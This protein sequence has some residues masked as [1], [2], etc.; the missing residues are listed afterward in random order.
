M[1]NRAL[2][3]L[4]GGLDSATVTAIAVK[5]KRECAA[6]TFSYGQRHTIEIASAKKLVEFFK[7]KNHIVIEIPTAVFQGSALLGQSGRDVPKNR[8]ISKLDEIPETY[9]PARNILFL[10]YALACAESVGIGDIYIGV[11]ALDYSGYPDCRP[12]FIAAYEKMANL[13][14]RSGVEGRPFRINA[15]LINLKKYEIIRLGTDLGVD[16]SLTHSCYDPDMTGASCGECDSCLLRKQ[17]FLQAGIPDPT[18]YRI[19]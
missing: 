13:G 19:K 2:V 11:N 8:D 16:Y 12:E 15:P 3:L 7:I 1:G 5:E 9:V 17:G 10:S 6:L 14:T 18:R 4:S